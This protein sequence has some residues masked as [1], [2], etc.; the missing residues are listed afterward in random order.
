[1]GPGGQALREKVNK[2]GEEADDRVIKMVGEALKHLKTLNLDGKKGNILRAE[3]GA[4]SGREW[5]V[6][7]SKQ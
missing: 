3:D 7:E 6:A 1:M 2:E 4:Y 5:I